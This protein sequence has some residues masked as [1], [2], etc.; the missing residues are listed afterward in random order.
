VRHSKGGASEYSKWQHLARQSVSSRLHWGCWY[1]CAQAGIE[2][3]NQNVMA[4]FSN[5]RNGTEIL[6]QVGRAT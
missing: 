4:Y 2:Q 3:I 1:A 6:K 5:F